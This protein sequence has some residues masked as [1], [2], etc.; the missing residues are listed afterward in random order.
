MDGL[1]NKAPQAYDKAMKRFALITAIFVALAEPIAAQ[2]F[3][4]ARAAYHSEDYATALKYLRPLAEQGYGPAK[5]QL[6]LMYEKGRGVLQDYSEA[7]KWLGKAVEKGNVKAKHD[8]ARLENALRADGNW[9][10]S[11]TITYNPED[12]ERLRR[13]NTC[14]KCD[15]RGANLHGAR[16]DNTG[17][18]IA[19]ATGAINIPEITLSK[20]ASKKTLEVKPKARVAFA[21]NDKAG[22]AA[23]R[24]G[25]WTTA[26]RRFKFRAEQKDLIAQYAIGVMYEHGRGVSQNYAEAFKWYRKAAVR[27]YTR[28]QFNLGWMYKHGKGVRKDNAEAVKWWR[29]TAKQGLAK[30]QF[31]LGVSYVDGKGVWMDQF[32]AHVW[33][34]VSA[35]NGYKRAKTA[36]DEVGKH[37]TSAEL[38]TSRGIFKRCWRKPVNCPE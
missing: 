10:P 2:D 34:S 23:H 11:P 4:S 6:G 36:R 14:P 35:A 29:K 13:T 22:M 37:L 28:A 33:L 38:N 5:R 20:V 31:N 19:A 15:L 24:R 8:L 26:L 21:S 12:L 18:T 32:L 25:D 17:I 1:P 9:P 30:G 7:V 27:G 3:E 16:L